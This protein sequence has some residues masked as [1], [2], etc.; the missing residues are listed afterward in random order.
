MT[1]RR[2]FLTRSAAAL[3]LAAGATVL[4]DEVKKDAKPRANRIAVSTYSFWQFNRSKLRWDELHSPDHVRMLDWYRALI[5]LRRR[6]PDL[7]DGNLRA[8]G[9]DFSEEQRWLAYT[10][11][12]AT[13]AFNVGEFE[14][15]IGN[16]RGVE[17]DTACKQVERIA[18]LRLKDM[19]PQ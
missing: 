17:F 9:V 5:D 12:R 19:L 16:S 14:A 7:S 18:L 10:R 8:V 1:T 15:R 11:G 2:D 4:G 13:V 6:Y 3:A